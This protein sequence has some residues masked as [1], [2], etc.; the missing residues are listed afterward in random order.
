MIFLIDPFI[1]LIYVSKLM[2]PETKPSYHKFDFSRIS[3]RREKKVNKGG[4][5]ESEESSEG[6]G[7]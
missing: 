7:N 4:F 3:T 5:Q 2:D 1:L 6:E